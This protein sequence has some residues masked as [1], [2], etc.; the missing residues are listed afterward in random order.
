MT[1]DAATDLSPVE[2]HSGAPCVCFWD[3]GDGNPWIY[4]GAPGARWCRRR[5]D[6]RGDWESFAGEI[7]GGCE[8]PKMVERWGLSAEEVA[9]IEE[10]DSDLPG[11]VLPPGEVVCLDMP[12]KLPS[13]FVR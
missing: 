11:G 5:A 1:Q 10:G 7:L 8:G 13:S 4:R 6:L 12:D 3:S 9:E 2:W